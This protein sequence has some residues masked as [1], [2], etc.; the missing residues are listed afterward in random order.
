MHTY[1]PVQGFTYLRRGEGTAEAH[2]PRSQFP[3]PFPSSTHPKTGQL[4]P[5][6]MSN[7][8]IKF[9]Y[10]PLTT[11]HPPLPLQD[12]KIL[13]ESLTVSILEPVR[14]KYSSLLVCTCGNSTACCLATKPGSLLL[15][16]LY[17]ASLLPPPPPPS[18]TPLEEACSATQNTL[19][20]MKEATN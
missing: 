20:N 1:S 16:L 15:P 17:V 4:P 2:P 13:D 7:H 11:L 10:N 18:N 6:L 3:P 9:K 19:I 14:D 8:K 12:K 5:R